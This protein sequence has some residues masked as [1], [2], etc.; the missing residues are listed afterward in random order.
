MDRRAQRIMIPDCLRE[1]MH[2]SV[3]YRRVTP[4]HGGHVAFAYGYTLW[5]MPGQNGDYVVRAYY[6]HGYFVLAAKLV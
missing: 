1:D 6:S 2:G 4:E 3:I 5:V